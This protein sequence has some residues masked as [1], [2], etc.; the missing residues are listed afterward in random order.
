MMRWPRIWFW[1]CCCFR[2]GCAVVSNKEGDLLSLD[3]RA[4]LFIG[5]AETDSEARL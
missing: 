1:L 2:V 3:R 4:R 5:K